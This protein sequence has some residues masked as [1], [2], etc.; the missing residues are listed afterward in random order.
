MTSIYKLSFSIG[1]LLFTFGNVLAQTMTKEQML[2]LTPQWTGERFEDGRPKVADD[3][4]ERMKNV[5]IEEAWGV[6]RNEGY[7]NQFESGW[8]PLHDDVPVVGRA[9][10]VQYMPNR[11]DVSD[12]IKKKGKADGR[13]G[14]TNSWPIDMLVEGDV[15][16]ADAFGK[17]VNGT[18]IGDNLGNSIYAKSKNGVVFNASSRDMEGLSE[19]D[20][21]NAFVRGWDPSFLTEVMLLSINTP[22]RI[23]AATVL[24]GD[25]VLAKREGIMFI[26][27]HLAEKVVVTS[28]VVRLRDLFGITRLKEGKYTPGQIDNKWSEEIEK[29]F[30]DWLRSHIDELPVPKEQVKELLE[31]RMW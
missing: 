2:F 8:Q 24:P 4:L 11:P 15:Y 28:E 31:K 7:H 3:V 13:I 23:G 21:F 22:I 19:I 20:G 9:L 18:L 30:S 5:T 12:Q 10:T 27:S 17:I 25:I 16:V 26:P 1:L 29:D 14:N 6:L